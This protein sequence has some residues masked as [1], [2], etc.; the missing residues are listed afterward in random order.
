MSWKNSLK[1]HLDVFNQLALH[2]KEVNEIAELIKDTLHNGGTIFVAGNGGSASDAQH[3]SAELTGRFLKERRSLA[4]IALTT[5]TSALTAI[6][7][8]YGFDYIFSRQ[9]SGLAKKGD[10]FIGITTSGNSSNIIKAIDVAKELLVKTVVL[11][12]RD[13][14][15]L[16]GKCDAEFIVPSDVTAHIQEAHI[17]V[18]H[19]ICQY[20]DAHFN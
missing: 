8:D 12:G 5:D 7:N 19:Y 1:N 9:L 2:E 11:T 6:G 4:G 15:K 10:L 18:L 13:G 16:K 17:F 3:F 14:G 20:L